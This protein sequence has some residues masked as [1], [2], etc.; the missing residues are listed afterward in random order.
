ML[1]GWQRPF[2]LSTSSGRL[3]TRVKFLEVGFV[4]LG[5]QVTGHPHGLSQDGFGGDEYFSD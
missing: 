5:Y 3:P 1:Y 2:D 4:V